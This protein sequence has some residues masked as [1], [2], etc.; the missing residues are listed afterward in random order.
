MRIH[1]LA[2]PR[3]PGGVLR[4]RVYCAIVLAVP[5]SAGCRETLTQVESGVV[6]TATWPALEIEQ[7]LPGLGDVVATGLAGGDE[8]AII[9]RWEATWDHGTALGEDLRDEI[10]RDAAALQPAP[11]PGAVRIAT[12]SVRGALGE[13]HRFGG[14]LPPHLARRIE[15]AGRFLEE[16]RE[17]AARK[18]WAVAGIR[19]LRAADV[20][21]ATSPRATALTLAEAA[22]DALGPPPSQIDSEAAGPARAR[23]LAWWSRIAI[24]RERYSLA[25]QRAYYACLLLGVRLP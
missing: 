3:G 12:E 2:L 4:G 17:A 22:E 11:D 21:R 13:V 18:G 7:D 5:L 16:S 25:I 24:E 15:D 8:V 10:Y 20:L 14:S 19:A 1:Q 6:E 9:A 23:R